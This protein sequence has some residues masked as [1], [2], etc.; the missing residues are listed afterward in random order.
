M[1]TPILDR[2]F[3][4]RNT[5]YLV[6]ISELYLERKGEGICR[7]QACRRRTVLSSASMAT[8]R[9]LLIR[10]SGLQLVFYFLK[11]LW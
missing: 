6:V 2:V 4:S 11:E 10:K 8:D 9:S 7:R 5:Q 3:L 1:N